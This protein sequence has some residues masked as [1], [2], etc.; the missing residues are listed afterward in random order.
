MMY[1]SLKDIG[2]YSSRLSTAHKEFVSFPFLL[3]LKRM[4]YDDV[5]SVESP[6]FTHDH[7]IWE[8]N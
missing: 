7:N 1:I 5:R 8:M 2:L 4:I 6:A 3:L